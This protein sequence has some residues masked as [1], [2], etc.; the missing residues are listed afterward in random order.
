MERMLKAFGASFPYIC[1]ADSS[2][3]SCQKPDPGV[4]SRAAR[5]GWDGQGGQ[6][7]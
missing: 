5:L 2:D 3:G 7:A 6:V 1:F 4:P